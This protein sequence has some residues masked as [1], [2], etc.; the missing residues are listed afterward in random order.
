MNGGGLGTDL[1]QFMQG[2]GNKPKPAASQKVVRDLP[3]EVPPPSTSCTVC[4]EDFE[5][6]ERGTCLPCTHFFHKDCLEPWLKDN[7]CCPNCRFEL[8]TDDAEYNKD[9]VAKMRARGI[10]PMSGADHKVPLSAATRDFPVG[11][12]VR[13]SGL[14]IRGDLNG[15]FGQVVGPPVQDSKNAQDWRFPVN[16]AGQTVLLRASNLECLEP[17]TP[18]RPST[19]S[20][21]AS[22]AAADGARHKRP[23]EDP[24]TS[25]SHDDCES[26]AA[27]TVCSGV[28]DN[29]RHRGDEAAH[30]STNSD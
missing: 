19:P 28:R 15:R 18:V 1:A 30:T 9:V 29:K 23:A 13:V 11:V 25:C 10:S 4:M 14:R 27:D 3:Q 7:N 20:S 22:P 24:H 8:L 2:G 5:A 17:P 12:R 6:E 21:V 16:V 26:Q